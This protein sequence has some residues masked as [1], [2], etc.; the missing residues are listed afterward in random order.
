MFLS[1]ATRQWP[2]L[3]KVPRARQAE[4]KQSSSVGRI[5]AGYRGFCIQAFWITESRKPWKAKGRELLRL[6]AVFKYQ[7]GAQQFQVF[8]L[9][10]ALCFQQ[11][12]GHPTAKAS[13]IGILP[14]LQ[15]RFEQAS[16]LGCNLE[17]FPRLL[18]FCLLATLISFTLKHR[19]FQ[20]VL[21][22]T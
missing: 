9:G 11:V 8:S 10:T 12:K 15:L 4:G 16:C 20:V 21:D 18:V 13:I 14:D 7:T 2:P 19:V 22:L 17:T 6:V 1:R 5:C 3:P